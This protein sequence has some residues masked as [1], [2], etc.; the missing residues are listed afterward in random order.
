MEERVRHSRR[1]GGGL[2]YNTLLEY[3][4]VVFEFVWPLMMTIL[5]NAMK[6]TCTSTSAMIKHTNF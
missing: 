2:D 1:G 5:K 3:I 4:C 6:S